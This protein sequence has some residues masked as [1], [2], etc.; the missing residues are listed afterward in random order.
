MVTW[1]TNARYNKYINIE[2]LL[3]ESL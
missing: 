3:L 1:L 2:R